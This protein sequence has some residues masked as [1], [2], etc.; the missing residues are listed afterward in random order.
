MLFV[1]ETAHLYLRVSLAPCQTTAPRSSVV[2]SFFCNG[3]QPS[4]L[5]NDQFWQS[6]TPSSIQYWYFSHPLEK[7]KIPIYNIV[8]L[9]SSWTCYIHE[10]LCYPYTP[11]WRHTCLKFTSPCVRLA[12][13]LCTR[14]I[15]SLALFCLQ[16][17]LVW[18]K[19]QCTLNG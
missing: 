14:V 17:W 7:T 5:T 12:L 13:L 15:T 1:T 11:T 16:Q 3:L 19:S 10:T 8:A 18:G 4:D 9:N 6:V 2:A